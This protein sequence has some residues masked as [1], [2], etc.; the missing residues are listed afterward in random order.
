[1]RKVHERHDQQVCHI[2]A[3]VYN[4]MVSLRTHLKE[5]GDVHE[6]RVDCMICGKWYKNEQYVR[7]HMKTAH[8]KDPKTVHCPHCG[9]PSPNRNALSK[10]ISTVHNYTQY[11]CH[12]CGKKFKQEVAL[13]VSP[14]KIASNCISS[15]MSC[16]GFFQ[17]HIATHTGVDLYTCA[18]CPKMFKCRSNMYKHQKQIHPKEWSADRKK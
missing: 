8:P 12:L 3:K 11:S 6:P 10:H 15:E 7:R 9:K 17:E 2:C 5:H 18:Y 4:S 16:F 13:K 14:Q 1:M